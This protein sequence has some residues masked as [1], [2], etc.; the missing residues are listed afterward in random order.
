M[1][2]EGMGEEVIQISKDIIFQE[3][4][5]ASESSRTGNRSMYLRN[6]KKANVARI[7]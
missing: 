1:N 4:E 2:T 5:T 3:E 6:S 7:E